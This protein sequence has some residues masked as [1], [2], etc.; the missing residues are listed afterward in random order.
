LFDPASPPE[1]ASA[2]DS[3]LTDANL[4]KSLGK[5]ARATVERDFSIDTVAK[6]YIALYRELI[7][8]KS[9]R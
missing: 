9:E 7:S 5:N 8:A 1:A 2:L 3:L 4:R 6:R